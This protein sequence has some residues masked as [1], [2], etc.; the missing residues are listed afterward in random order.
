MTRYRRALAAAL[1]VFMAVSLLA[2][3]AALAA[4]SREEPV[5]AIVT[6]TPEAP[7]EDLVSAIE[8]LP[9]TEVL[10]TYERTFSGVAVEAVPSALEEIAAL[11]G[12]ENA[13][14]AATR[15][16]QALE[17]GPIANSLELM[18]P[19]ETTDLY[20]DGVVIAVIDSGFRLSHQA[21]TDYGLAQNPALSAE[22]VA[23]FVQSGGTPGRYISSR[24]PFAYDYWGRDDDAGTND[25]HGTHVA[26][27]AAG[28]AMEEDGAVIFR[29]AAPAAQILAMKVFPDNSGAGADDT[30]ILKAM[31]DA[32]ALGADIITLSLGSAEGFTAYDAMGGL[33]AQAFSNLR[34]QGILLCCAAGN[35]AV[36]TAADAQSS[37]LPSGGYT[38]YGT[39]N[40]PAS[41]PGATAV[42]AVDALHYA[43]RGYIA[44]G[45][46]KI[47]FNDSAA[48]GTQ[49]L[50]DLMELEGQPLALALVGGVGRT[51]DF[52]AVD[53][54]GKIALVE[55]GDITF[56]EK[57]AN[58]AAAGAVACLIV[59]NEPGS[60]VPALESSA[61]PCAAI[62]QEDG[63]YL[64]QLAQA[65]VV[66][67]TVT[68][69]TFSAPYRT[70]LTPFSQSSWGSTADLRLVPTLAAPGGMI[71]SAS[72]AGDSRYAFQSGTSMAAPNAASAMAAVLEAMTARGFTGKEAADLTEAALESTA[73]LL[74][75][76]AGLPLSPRQQGAGL[77]QIAAGAETPVILTNPLAELGDSDSGRF[78][79]KLTFRN[80]SQEDVTLQR[81]ITVL[82]D[83]FVEENGSFHSL[84]TPRDITDQVTVAGPRSVTVPAGGE[85]SISLTL[86]VSAA[87]RQEL[88]QPFP[89]GFF[90][91]GFVTFTGEDGTAIHATFLGYCGDWQGAPIL[92]QTDFTHQID[93][94]AQAEETGE[95]VT[96]ERDLG[97]NLAYIS[98]S[99]FQEALSPL[100][101]ENLYLAAAYDESRCALPGGNSDALYTAGNL[102]ATELYTLRH[103]R[104]IIM[105]VS[106]RDTG[107]VYAAVDQPYIPKTAADYRFGLAFP[108]EGFYWDG[109]DAQGSPV[110]GGTQ[111]TV[112]FYAWLEGDT[113]M[114]QA[115]QNHKAAVSDPA[116]YG[117]L[118]D[119]SYDRCL[120]WR[121]SLTI[122]D[123]SPVITAQRE[124]EDLIIT[125]EDD[126]YLAYAALRDGDGNL[127]AQEAWADETA[128]ESHTFTLAGEDL[129]DTLYISAQ[130]YATNTTGLALSLTGTQ[131]ESHRCA[132]ALLTDVDK[133]AWYHEAVDYV[134]SAGLMEGSEDL[135]F[136]PTDGAT[137][138]Q[139][140]YSLYLL[141][142]SPES[143][144]ELPFNDV[145]SNE[146]YY[147]ALCWA[148]ENGIA[149]GYSDTIFGAMAPVKRQQLAVMLQRFA[150]L[151]G[152]AQ[153]QGDLSA[154][155][156]GD[157]VSS[158][159]AEAM[160]WTV[161]EGLLSGG[162]EGQLNPQANTTRAE[163]AQILMN[164]AS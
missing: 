126:Q 113:A 26:A 45:E 54:T 92:S 158:W 67:V 129:P 49:L 3:P 101:G 161:E 95:A 78:T 56:A 65:G 157:T 142:G 13:V 122:D 130:D 85:A 88:S 145:P 27:L 66:T 91:E 117:W 87:L 103:A 159:A 80:I 104:R 82:T 14:P 34:Q 17:A 48:T 53:V 97:V 6:F 15:Q 16:P 108:L 100:L 19:A 115:Y 47:S 139:V 86:S 22:D 140:I 38:D 125:I 94:Q 68:D 111:V 51:E 36:S 41:Y 123:L 24:I 63:A 109:T 150:A 147:D 21:F 28:L 156:D 144:A 154:F 84:L 155:S 149:Q 52:A 46:R 5:R 151:T 1:G 106:D 163:L 30:V 18:A 71:L 141:A 137:R 153:A 81:D 124:G 31:E 44:A 11:P 152:E 116:R 138:A 99:G 118:L 135:I 70:A 132:V 120:Q 90:T 133:D 62:S 59:N 98:H 9:D 83:D 35:D 121:F 23:A 110:P 55:R 105:V 131:A 89:N 4:E 136:Q 8:T 57:A 134:Y 160:A 93:A 64:R 2:A 12:V 29:G 164:L 37:G 162:P 96:V 10:W 76:E 39:I 32:A 143:D 50:P 20:G 128:G 75:D 114:D 148:W 58:A 72:V 74:T 61:I 42:A 40:A 127:L 77:V 33:Y 107:T 69:K 102:L 112:S 60:I 43:A 73:L 119:A 25:A 7:A 146:W 79:L